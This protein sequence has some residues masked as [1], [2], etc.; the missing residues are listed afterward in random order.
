[1]NIETKFN[2]KDQVYFMRN[3]EIRKEQIVGIEVIFGLRGACVTSFVKIEYHFKTGLFN[4]TTFKIE[5]RFCFLNKGLL[6]ESIA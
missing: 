3:S 4:K 2:K 6:L 1:M 5:E